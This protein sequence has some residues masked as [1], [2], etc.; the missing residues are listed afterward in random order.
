MV[1][2]THLPVLA[3]EVARLAA[4]SRRAVDA[5]V[6]EG[7]H[8]A[9]LRA[10]GA[11][12]LAID[13]DP[14][15]IR[16][17]QARLG[18]DGLDWHCGRF[19]D[20][21]TLAAI[22]QFRP[23]LVLFDLGVSSRHLNNDARGFSFRPNVALDMRMGGDGV[24]AAE[25]LNRLPQPD[26]AGLFRDLA[27]ERKAPKL[28]GAIT[29]RRERQP[30]ATSDDLVNAIRSVL[31]P[32]SGP[33]DFARL[34]QAVR[35]A[36]NDELGQLQRALPGARDALVPGGRMIVISYHSG[37]DR[38]V[39][40]AFKEWARSCICPPRSPVCTC[41]GYALGRVD[42]P[43]PIVPT[44]E[45]LALNPRARSAKLRGFVCGRDA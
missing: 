43:R 2:T 26:L 33:S 36:V 4:G 39:K 12:V 10:L 11:T 8:T 19:G 31:G 15:A 40:H 24:T 44:A 23:D 41:R 37:E 7:G 20:E 34:F 35:M 1:S 16:S 22:H 17:A 29:R 38:V 28:A 21:A 45:E 30:F 6:G 13:R 3:D 9:R 27:D 25:L 5:T 32:R 14:E 42:P 18:G